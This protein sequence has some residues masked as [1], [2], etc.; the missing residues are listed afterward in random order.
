MTCPKC[1]GLLTPGD[2]AEELRC[3]NCGRRVNRIEAL[4]ADL[5]TAAVAPPIT[6]EPK[7]VTMAERCQ[8]K[9]G[10]GFCKAD[11]VNGSDFCAAHRETAVTVVPRRARTPIVV[12]GSA[13]GGARLPARSKNWTR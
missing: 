3:I 5:R 8:K 9:L 6:T 7:E 4:R 13:P 12:N 11:A 1:Q 10:R 2:E